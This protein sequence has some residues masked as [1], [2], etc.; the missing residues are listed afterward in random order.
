MEEKKFPQFV[1]ATS[2][3]IYYAQRAEDLA[4]TLK[5]LGYILTKGVS[6]TEIALDVAHEVQYTQSKEIRYVAEK[7][8]ITLLL[9]GS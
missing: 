7:Q 6:A 9:H 3:G 2:S 4:T 5:K 8:G 1:I